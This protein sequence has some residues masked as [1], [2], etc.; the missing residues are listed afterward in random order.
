MATDDTIRP[1]RP[2]GPV[3]LDAEDTALPDAAAPAEAAPAE[4]DH[5]GET[6]ERALAL[7]AGSGSG[8]WASRLVFAALGGIVAMAIGI[9][10][11]DFYDALAA[12]SVWLGR[13]GLILLAVVVGAVL[14]AAMREVAALGRLR[15]IETVRRLAASVAPSR[16]A[17]SGQRLLSTLRSFYAGRVEM[18][19]ALADFERTLPELLDG[20]AVLAQAERHAMASLDTAAEH[21][22]SRTAQR[23]AGF[24]ALV[25][26]P[27]LDVV[28]VLYQN[29]AM[30]RRIAEIYGGRSGWLGSWRLLRSVAQHLVATGAIAA[31]DDLLGPLVGGGVLGQISRRFGEATVN[32]ALTAR[33]G[34]AAIEVCRPLPFH[35]RE[36]PRARSLV[37][38][39]LP[40]W[41]ASG[42]KD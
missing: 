11:A 36:P 9:W 26:M 14:V 21:A 35:D 23:V 16:G 24:T 42:T 32:A 28:L 20:A 19:G 6:A 40:G 12:R 17:E 5:P 15:R 27:A 41:G 18:Q 4:P 39:A 2:R 3:I 25:P 30:I 38:R 37:L 10:V 34:V 8:R 13:L 31:T 1:K 22:V 33:V 7:A 29:A